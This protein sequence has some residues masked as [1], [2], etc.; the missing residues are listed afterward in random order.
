MILKLLTITRPSLYCFHYVSFDYVV[1]L[2]IN[3][4]PLITTFF[5]NKYVNVLL[6]GILSQRNLNELCLQ[7]TTVEGVI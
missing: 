3:F 2:F 6:F 1:T 7:L 4:V 5:F